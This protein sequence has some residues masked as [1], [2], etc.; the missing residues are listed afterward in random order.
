MD[1]VDGSETTTMSKSSKKQTMQID[2]SNVS[3]GRR[4][5]MGLKKAV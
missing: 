2:I 3:V 1:E 4:L 5:G